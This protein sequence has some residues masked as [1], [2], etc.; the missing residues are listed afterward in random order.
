MKASCF[1]GRDT[2]DC[3]TSSVVGRSGE[4]LLQQ[5]RVRPVE[6]HLRRDGRCE[7][8]AARHP[9]GACADGRQGD[10]QLLCRSLYLA[11]TRRLDSLQVCRIHRP[12]LRDRYGSI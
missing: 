12:S 4:E 8:G 1:L 3:L 11:N 2:D 9:D 6:A 5:H 10:A 7:Q